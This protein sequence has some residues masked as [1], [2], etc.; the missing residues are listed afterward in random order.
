MFTFQVSSYC[1][2]VLQRWICELSDVDER[3]C[4]TDLLIFPILGIRDIVYAPIHNTEF[5]KEKIQ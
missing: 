1:L 4:R 5:R 2:L 3:S